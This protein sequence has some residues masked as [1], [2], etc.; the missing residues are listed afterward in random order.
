MLLTV[1]VDDSAD[2]TQERAIVAGAYVGFFPQWSKLNREW[3]KRLKQDGLRFFHT[4]ECWSLRGEFVR[5]RDPVKYPRPS[6]RNS[7][8]AILEDLENIIHTSGVMGVAVSIDMRAYNNV[9][10]T[11]P[12]ASTIFPADA[13][14]AALQTLVGTCAGIVRD[15]FKGPRSLRFVCDNSESAGRLENTYKQFKGR[16]K[17]LAQF[18]RDLV[19]EDDKQFPQLQAADM[20]AHIA[21]RRFIEWLDDPSKRIFTAESAMRE[22]LKRLSMQGIGIWDRNHMM[23]ILN[24]ERSRRGLSTS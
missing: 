14:E 20:L 2:E 15:N 19:H 18:L 23:A 9:R 10:S 16:N 24:D 12:H 13:F 5:F 22:R 21:K 8:T 17:D 6:G 4:T 11:E 1:Y 3:R 7:A